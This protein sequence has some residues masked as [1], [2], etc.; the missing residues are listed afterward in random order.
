MVPRY[1]RAW[2]PRH[3]VWHPGTLA[4]Y[5]TRQSCLAVG[6]FS[7]AW[8]VRDEEAWRDQPTLVLVC[9]E[10]PDPTAPPSSGGVL[11]FVRSMVLTLHRGSWVVEGFIGADDLPS[12]AELQ[13]L[14]LERPA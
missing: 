4:P 6:L 2:C 9:N 3:S 13:V 1:A 12:E 8:R 11:W 14:P 7:P 5:P 10:G